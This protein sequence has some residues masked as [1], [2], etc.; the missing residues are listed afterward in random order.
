MDLK[1]KIKAADDI[2]RQRIEVPEWG[3]ELEVR[4]ITGANRA[5]LL[6]ETTDD[7]GK[8]IFGKLYPK[9]LIYSLYDPKTNELIFSEK[10]ES[11]LMEKNGT[12]IEKLVNLAMGFS[13]L[14]EGSI[15]KAEKN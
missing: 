14:S 1:E 12:P 8:V 11:W 6:Q 13:G 9:L 3:V 10:D 7:E 4:S 5:K 15:A 2:S